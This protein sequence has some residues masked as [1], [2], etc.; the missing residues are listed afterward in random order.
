MRAARKAVVEAVFDWVGSEIKRAA[1]EVPKQKVA[2]E[3]GPRSF[4]DFVHFTFAMHPCSAITAT[5]SKF[6]T[7]KYDSFLFH[8]QEIQICDLGK[9]HRGMV[10]VFVAEFK[11]II[12]YAQGR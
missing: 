12:P 8:A 3:V 5:L 1:A 11:K 4:I 6:T 9:H 10:D 7:Q 2:L